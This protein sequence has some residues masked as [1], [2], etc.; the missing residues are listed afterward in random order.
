MEEEIKEVVEKST[1]ELKV[2][3]ILLIIL[4]VILIVVI[5]LFFLVLKNNKNTEER[6]TIINSM[7]NFKI[8]NQ[9]L[10]KISKDKYEESFIKNKNKF[11]KNINT[12]ENFQSLLQ[13]GLIKQLV[14]DY[15]GAEEIWLYAYDLNLESYVLNGNLAHL[16]QYF[17]YDYEKSE[18]YYLQ[19]LNFKV[20][21]A[22]A[23]HYTYFSELYDLYR[24]RIKD[25]D[26][27]IKILERAIKNL[28]GEINIYFLSARYYKDIGDVNKARYYFNEALKINPNSSVAQKGLEELY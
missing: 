25:K 18:K 24:Y 23:N 27:I 14:G 7:V 26:K 20:I 9:E 8:V 16:Y 19:A 13:M 15:K 1:D 28:P 22:T 4:I 17:I 12:A 10:D 21:G 3:K 11:I 5:L 2:K 6:E